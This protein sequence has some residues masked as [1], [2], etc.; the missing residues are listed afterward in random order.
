MISRGHIAQ[1]CSEWISG[2]I[3]RKLK[4]GSITCDLVSTTLSLTPTLG[5]FVLISDF[6]SYKV[7][8]VSL[9]IPPINWTNAEPASGRQAAPQP[10]CEFFFTPSFAKVNLITPA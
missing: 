4:H 6:Q 5:L 9:T 1:P 7:Q 10:Y 3:H 2:G 8:Q